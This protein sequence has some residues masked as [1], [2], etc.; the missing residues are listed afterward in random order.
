MSEFPTPR[1]DGC[2]IC[3]L[4][5]SDSMRATAYSGPMATKIAAAQGVLG[6]IVED[7][8]QFAAESPADPRNVDVAVLAYSTRP[9]GKP[10]LR[11]LLPGSSAGRPLLPLGAVAASA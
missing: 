9:D 1:G 2:L 6:R 11:P 10:R 5:A 7:L 3:L 4:Q 8:V